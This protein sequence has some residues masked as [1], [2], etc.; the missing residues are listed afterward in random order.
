MADNIQPN[1]IVLKFWSKQSKDAFLYQF[2][3]GWGESKIEFEW[4]DWREG[5]SLEEAR[6]L[7][8]RCFWDP[9]GAL[10]DETYDGEWWHRDPSDADTR[11]EP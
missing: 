11:L 4:I 10:E 2:C 7:A 1:E 6:V 3:D 8:I 5:N 9:S